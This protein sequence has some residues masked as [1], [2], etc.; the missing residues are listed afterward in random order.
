MNV[1]KEHDAHE[2]THMINGLQGLMET[3]TDTSLSFVC[4]EGGPCLCV[5]APGPGKQLYEHVCSAVARLI[6]QARRKMACRLGQDVFSTK[7][8][9]RELR[10]LLDSNSELVLH[11]LHPIDTHTETQPTT[12]THTANDAGA[13]TPSNPHTETPTQ[14]QPP[15]D[16]DENAGQSSQSS[17]TEFDS[18]LAVAEF[19]ITKKLEDDKAQVTAFFKHLLTKKK[20]FVDTLQQQFANQ[21]AAKEQEFQNIQQKV[22]FQIQEWQ[23]KNQLLQSAATEWRAKYN[24]AFT[25]NTSLKLRITKCN[26]IRNKVFEMFQK[27]SFRL[28]TQLAT[29]F[30]VT[31]C[32]M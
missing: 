6:L 12:H 25:E 7:I 1:D 32:C 26:Q 20:E 11:N 31:Q 23:S 27:V 10:F 18:M 9:V 15:T 28:T 13:Q 21:L 24:A 14:T 8:M 17:L 5:S 2:F 30:H 16:G 29:Q 19:M 3:Y 22:D 4:T